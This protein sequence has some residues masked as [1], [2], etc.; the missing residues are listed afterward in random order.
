MD[1]P[2]ACYR[3]ECAAPADMEALVLL[4]RVLFAIEPDFAIDPT[5]Q[6]R[7]LELLL[8]DP[9]R[10]TV[11]V[12]RSSTDRSILGMV[13]G[14]LVISTAEGSPSLWVEDLIVHQH[15]RTRGV[16]CA[17][18]SALLAWARDH[19]VTRAQLL[20]DAHNAPALAFY[21][22]LGWQ[23]TNMF[24]RRLRLER[25]ARPSPHTA[26]ESL[27]ECADYLRSAR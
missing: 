20:A 18:L 25:A 15:A 16:G 12:A 13:T 19:G 26:T 4:L 7:G 10:A 14:Q 8:A 5:R 23:R 21:E 6:R 11:L 9:Q 17:L 2:V 3:V 1:T 24:A 27:S 22:H